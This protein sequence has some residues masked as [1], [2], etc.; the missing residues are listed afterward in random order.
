MVHMLG[1]NGE[2]LSRQLAGIIWYNLLVNAGAAASISCLEW[3]AFD[4]TLA[5]NQWRNF[6]QAQ[7]W[8]SVEQLFQG[9]TLGFDGTQWFLLV[10]AGKY[11]FSFNCLQW[12]VLDGTCWESVEN[13]CT[14]TL[15]GIHG[16]AFSR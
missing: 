2:T 6:V 10:F 15:L 5:G 9:D 4:S 11:W 14:S 16:A 1:N 8:E 12:M 13:L 3:M 7:C